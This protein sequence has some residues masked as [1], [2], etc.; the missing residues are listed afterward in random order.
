MGSVLCLIQEST[1]DCGGCSPFYNCQL[2]W[3]IPW[4]CRLYGMFQKISIPPNTLSP[5]P[6]WKFKFSFIPCLLVAPLPSHGRVQLLV[7]TCH[8]E[9]EFTEM[10]WYVLCLVNNWQWWLSVSDTGIPLHVVSPS[11][12]WINQS[13]LRTRQKLYCPDIIMQT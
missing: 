2:W 7:T 1:F 8:V 10:W 4:C 3:S 5:T 13:E 11:E 9:F 12:I 6:I